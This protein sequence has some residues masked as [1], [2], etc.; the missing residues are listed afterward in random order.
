MMKFQ[1]FPTH[2]SGLWRINAKLGREQALLPAPAD[3]VVTKGG[4]PAAQNAGQDAEERVG[5]GIPT[6]A[7][8]LSRRGG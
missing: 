8:R 4:A 6:F 2:T 5:L 3:A 7:P 1:P